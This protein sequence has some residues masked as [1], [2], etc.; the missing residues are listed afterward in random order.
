MTEYVIRFLLG[1]AVV[2]AFAMFVI[3]VILYA[4]VARRRKAA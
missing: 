4:V 2:S 3:G 1:G